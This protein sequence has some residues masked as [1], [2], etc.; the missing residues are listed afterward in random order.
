LKKKINYLPSKI[1]FQPFA[2]K[3]A[4]F[5]EKASWIEHEVVAILNTFGRA[6]T[7]LYIYMSLNVLAARYAVKTWSW[8]RVLLF[9]PGNPPGQNFLTIPHPRD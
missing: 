2:N 8:I 9:T 7:E 1:G 4:N 3:F 5:P 6:L